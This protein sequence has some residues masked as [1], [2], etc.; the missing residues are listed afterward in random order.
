MED[1]GTNKAGYSGVRRRCCKYAEPHCTC[2]LFKK[3]KT[4]S[5]QTHVLL[6]VV[7]QDIFPVFESLKSRFTA[8]DS[9]WS[10]NR[11]VKGASDSGS[12]VA[13]NSTNKNLLN[14]GFYLV[15]GSRDVNHFL[16]SQWV[17]CSATNNSTSP[18]YKST[19]FACFYALLTH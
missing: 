6:Q 2:L 12:L 7:L 5:V 14:S 19:S 15:R 1:S 9:F 8:C 4:V 18:A 17:S 13:V 16:Y 3:D 11:L 10:L